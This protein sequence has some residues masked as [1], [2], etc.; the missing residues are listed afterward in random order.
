MFK[1]TINLIHS[2]HSYLYQS[3][4]NLIRY[5]LKFLTN[6]PNLP[7][8]EYIPSLFLSQRKIF[9]HLFYL[10]TLQSLKNILSQNI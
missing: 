8:Q 4:Q 6:L 9:E 2:L 3:N 7:T 5:L 10:P 1:A